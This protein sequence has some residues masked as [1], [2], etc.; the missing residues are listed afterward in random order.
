MAKYRKFIDNFDYEKFEEWLVENQLRA[1]DVTRELNVNSSYFANARAR[2]CMN[3]TIYKLLCFTYKLPEGT[4][5]IEKKEEQ[6]ETKET[7]VEQVVTVDNSEVVAKLDELNVSINKLGN[8]LM[9]LL[10]YVNEIKK[11]LK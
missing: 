11:E 10:E 3:Y 1:S 5:L 7:A 2:N 8:V 6:E 4:F 9:Q